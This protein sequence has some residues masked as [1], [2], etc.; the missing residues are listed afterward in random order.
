MFC[1]LEDILIFSANKMLS[2]YSG[3]AS[4]LGFAMADNNTP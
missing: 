1:W 2:F 3:E 4:A